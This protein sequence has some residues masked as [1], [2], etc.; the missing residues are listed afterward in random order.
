[1]HG[2]RTRAKL[3][4]QRR[5]FNRFLSPVHVA[6]P[7]RSHRDS[8][9]LA[10]LEETQGCEPDGKEDEQPER[11]RRIGC[12]QREGEPRS[13]HERDRAHRATLALLTRPYVRET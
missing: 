8:S 13:G 1:M 10:R 4:D 9:L 6:R 11:A 12:D 5:I 2:A 3:S 7:A